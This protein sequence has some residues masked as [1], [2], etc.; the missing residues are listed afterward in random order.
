M[1]GSR[2]VATRVA[3]DAGRPAGVL[4]ARR[5][6]AHRPH[7]SSVPSCRSIAVSSISSRRAAADLRTRPRRGAARMQQ[8]V[9]EGFHGAPRDPDRALSRLRDHRG[10]ACGARRGELGLPVVVKADGLAAGKGVVVAPIADAR[11]P[12]SRAAMDDRQFGDAGARVVLEE[13]LSGPEV[14]FFAL[15]DGTRAVAAPLGAGSQ[16]HL[17]RRSRARTPAGWG[18]SRPARC[19][20]T[21][22]QAT[23]QR[24]IIEP[25]LRGLAAEG[26]RVPRLPL[27]RPDA[28]VRRPESDRVQRA[29]R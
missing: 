26:A 29:V 25:V 2:A 3:V 13:C 23:V 1:P 20:T 24:D 19:S 5:A 28:D 10:R 11:T 6:R 12:R 9:R 27:R 14:S 21:A 16:A 7:R 15:C 18:R 8:G 4:D 22:M 17:R